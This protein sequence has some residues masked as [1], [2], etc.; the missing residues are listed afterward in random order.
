[1]AD[2]TKNG[3]GNGGAEPIPGDDKFFE[4]L[5]ALFD[6]HDGW[7]QRLEVRIVTG[8][9]AERLGPFIEQFPFQPET[10]IGDSAVEGEEESE[11][12]NKKTVKKNTKPTR[13]QLVALSNKILFLI[14]R[15]CDQQGKPVMYSA[16]A[17]HFARGV[18]YYSRWLIK[19]QP[20]GI[21]SNEDS[22][23][24]DEEDE[25]KSLEKRFGVQV[26]HH[27][28]RSANLWGS[29]VENMM[30][31]YDRA[32]ERLE[33]SH[34]ATRL[35]LERTLEMLER[36]ESNRHQR[37]KEMRWEDVKIQS[38]EKGL[39]L[40]FDMAPPLLNQLAGKKSN[41]NGGEDDLE[42]LTIRR[43][44]KPVAE[45][46]QLT[47]EQANATFGT[48]DDEVNLVAPGV[49]SQEQG[50]LIV[51]VA[52]GKASTDR[53]DDLLPGGRLEVTQEQI[54]QLVP[55]VFSM[56]QITPI[57][58]LLGMRMENK[59]KRSQQQNGRIDQERA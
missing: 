30:D 46:G 8:R 56:E 39:N 19:C 20:K 3:S 35:R 58:T 27:G 48:F 16:F 18:D 13:E 14:Q 32:F 55:R 38:V 11:D 23:H 9:N 4:W 45:G 17:S 24:D 2:K 59:K 47:P 36:A 34:E 25:D 42:R 52:F 49:F 29:M 54:V 37:E 33:A 21:R 1:M 28:E 15:D 26:L 12:K 43:F 10:K 53:L 5:E 7:P 40:A 22:R 6:S 50:Q 31:R 41:G 57:M 44:L 51:D